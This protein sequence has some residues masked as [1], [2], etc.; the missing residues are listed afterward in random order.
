MR[1]CWLLDES[2][3]RIAPAIDTV[4]G[5]KEASI[6]GPGPD[7][8]QRHP[9]RRACATWSPRSP[10]TRSPSRSPAGPRTVGSA[11]AHRAI[12]AALRSTLDAS[13]DGVL[14]L[15]DLGSA[16]LSLELA[17]EDLD[18]ADASGSASARRRWSRG[19]SSP[20]SRPASARRWPRSRPPPRPRPRCPS[21]R[22]PDDAGT[23]PDRRRSGRPARPSGGPVRPGG[24]AVREPD[25]DPLRRPRGG[26]QEPHRAARPDDPPVVRDHLSAEG[27]DADAA[28]AALR[29][30]W[31]PTSASTPS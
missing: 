27:P 15:F 11:R 16:A 5:R 18:P 29:P 2:G 24:I 28:L 8:P 13:P 10:A 19:R 3:R 17:L 31:R 4:E 22:G 1:R 21:S 7:L 26:R 14:V 12:A 6:G 20:P 30:S 25:R 23:D 9:G